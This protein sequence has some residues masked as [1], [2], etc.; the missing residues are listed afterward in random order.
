MYNNDPQK[1]DVPSYSVY[2]DR[3]MH[4]TYSTP[5]QW[6]KVLQSSASTTDTLYLWQ[7]VSDCAIP[8]FLFFYYYY[9]VRTKRVTCL[10]IYRVPIQ[11]Q[12]VPEVGLLK[13]LYN[14]HCASEPPGGCVFHFLQ[15]LRHVTCCCHKLSTSQSIFGL[16]KEV[17]LPSLQTSRPTP[18]LDPFSGHRTLGWSSRLSVTRIDT[19]THADS[20][21]SS[22]SQSSH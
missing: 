21:Q 2:A 5:L 10:A 17:G 19:D 11:F 4:E 13:W 22:Q 3:S 20:H 9:P 6:I 12:I 1:S 8:Y 18:C 15:S 7:K 16:L 14:I